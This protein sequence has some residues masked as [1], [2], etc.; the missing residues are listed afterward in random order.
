MICEGPRWQSEAPRVA[1]KLWS[2]KET[3]KIEYHQENTLMAV[4]KGSEHADK[5]KE[6]RK[7]KKADAQ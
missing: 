3:P 7:K 2:S 1:T 4:S 6:Q 5:G